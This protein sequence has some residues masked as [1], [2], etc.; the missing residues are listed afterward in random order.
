MNRGIKMETLKRAGTQL[1]MGV[2]LL[3]LPAVSAR[4]FGAS[5]AQGPQSLGEAEASLSQGQK[6]QELQDAEQAQ[7]EREQEAR[8]REQEKKDRE[9]ERLDRMQEL[10]DDGRDDL[11]EEK[12]QYAEQKFTALAQMNGP[13]TDAALYWKAFAENKQGKRDAALS[14]IAELKKSFPQSRWKKD[15]EALE[16]EVRQG[17]GRPV[18]P[19]ATSD[20]DLKALALQGIMNSDPQRAIPMIEKFLN[21]STSP[22]E[23]AKYLFVLAQN[24]SPQA[25]EALARIA[26]GQS[27]P[28]LQRKA[29][30]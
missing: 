14:T 17:T 18:N 15:A 20:S 7:R 22:K 26:R 9:Q 8:D 4:A 16:I 28:D 1:A 29:V 23:K 27:N 19:D 10:Y 3:G 2:L 11:D 12:Y 13:Q 30:E 21:S 5:A 6:T 25:Q 24:G